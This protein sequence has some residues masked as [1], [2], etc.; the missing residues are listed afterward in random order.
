MNGRPSSF[1][2]DKFKPLQSAWSNSGIQG[3]LQAERRKIDVPRYDQRIEESDAAFRRYVE[4]VC[5]QEFE[6][7]NA[8]LFITSIALSCYGSE[9]FFA[10]QFL[11]HQHLDDLQKRLS[12]QAFELAKRF[13]LENGTDLSSLRSLTF[14][15]K[16][17]SN[18]SE[19]RQRR[20]LYLLLEFLAP[21]W[22][23]AKP[24]SL[25]AG[26]FKARPSLS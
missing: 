16:Q 14:L 2:L 1:P 3:D 25:P 24:A 23:S 9:R 20:S 17:L 22:R 18:L 12:N 11:S 13:L 21:L 7:G 4:N 8:H 15:K 26:S 19:Q 10:P 5:I 6:N